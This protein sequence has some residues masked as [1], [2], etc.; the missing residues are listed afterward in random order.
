MVSLKKLKMKRP[1]LHLPGKKK[2]AKKEENA[3]I[4]E[5]PTI[6][7]PSENDPIMEDR[8]DAGE[9][10]VVTEKETEVV[11]KIEE[12][13]RSPPADDESILTDANEYTEELSTVKEESFEKDDAE[14]KAVE[15]DEEAPLPEPAVMT[16][17]EGT[18]SYIE[19]S[20][21]ESASILDEILTVDNT[22]LKSEDVS[23][24]ST[25]A[26]CGGFCFKN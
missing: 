18:P 6:K 5:E 21:T 12:D 20:T 9:T 16:A 8:E 25:S 15:E 1:T 4:E 24:V 7:G 23:P 17:K 3:M 2:H 19:K 14:E 13:E 11:E 22:I 26:F 10:N